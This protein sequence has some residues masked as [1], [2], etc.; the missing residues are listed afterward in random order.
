[1]NSTD[2][3]VSATIYLLEYTAD[4]NTHTALT[5][6]NYVKVYVHTTIL[7]IGVIGD[8]RVRKYSTDSSNRLFR[9]ISQ[10]KLQIDLMQ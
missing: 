3:L 7:A 6:V 9:L 4:K 5:T 8:R 1:M 10:L 2:S